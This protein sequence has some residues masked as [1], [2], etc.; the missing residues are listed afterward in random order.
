MKDKLRMM[1]VSVVFVS[2]VGFLAGCQSTG[3]A[4]RDISH[5]PYNVDGLEIEKG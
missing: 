3:T 2:V 5:D 1:I 4:T